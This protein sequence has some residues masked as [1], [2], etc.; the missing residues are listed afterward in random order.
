[1]PET[2]AKRNYKSNSRLHVALDSTLLLN[3]YMENKE[4]RRLRM[5]EIL[6]RFND[7]VAEM[8]RTTDTDANYLRTIRRGERDMGDE[9]ARKFEATLSLS[10]GWMDL[11]PG[12]RSDN[13][14]SGVPVT[15]TAQLGDDGYWLEEGYPVGSGGGYIRY[16]TK[17]PGTYAL[18]VKGDSMRPRIKP[19][20]FVVIEPAHSFV[21]G[22]EVMV[23]TMDG[24]CMI[25]ILGWT[26]DGMVELQSVN[27]DHRP[28]TLEQN[29]IDKIH[30][31]GAIVKPSWYY[32]RT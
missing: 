10:E 7:N 18:R 20:E 5:L 28:I 3:S 9:L 16:P 4:I 26:R 17:D 30:Y 14:V 25:K 11:A 21:S 22:D 1:M 15:G 6:Q 29:Q 19:G 31:V 8:A 2:I 13:E 24:R 27:N 12:Q 32:E 23:K